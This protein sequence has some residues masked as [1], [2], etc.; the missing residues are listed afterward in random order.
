MLG[1]GLPEDALIEDFGDTNG[2]QNRVHLQTFPVI[3]EPQQS[4]QQTT[5]LGINTDVSTGQPS[6]NY[7]VVSKNQAPGQ[8]FK[9][10][11]QVTPCRDSGPSQAERRLEAL[12]LELEKELEMHMK[13]EYFGK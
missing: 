10:P 3:P 13:K 6:F 12:T 4:Q 5:Q 8:R 7:S 11:Y 2:L 9:L 1:P